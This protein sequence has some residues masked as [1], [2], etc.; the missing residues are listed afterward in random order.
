MTLYKPAGCE[1]C[2]QQGFKGRL[3]ILE[4]LRIDHEIDDLIAKRASYREIEEVAVKNGFVNLAESASN[5]VLAGNTTLDEA[6]RTVDLT[7]RL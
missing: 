1:K 3:P 5:Q 7:S 2:G 6:I 4:V